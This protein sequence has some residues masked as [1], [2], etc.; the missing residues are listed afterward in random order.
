MSP[1]PFKLA[2]I[3]MEVRGGE[4]ERNLEQALKQIAEA[5]SQGAEVILLPECLDLGWTHPS[6][7]TLAE[8]I[9][10]GR[11]CQRLAEAAQKHE[12]YIC[13]GLTEKQGEKIY[14]SAVLINP[15]GE[16]LLKHRKLN[17]L[18]IGHA[19]YAQG[20]GLQ[21]AQT[22]FGTIGVMICADGFATGQVI[23]RSLCYMGADVILSPCAWAR[24]ADHDNEL[25]PYGSVWRESYKPVAARFSTAIFGTSNVGPITDGPWKGRKCVGCSLAID[26]NGDEMFQGPYGEACILYAEVIP[27]E[28]P[29]RGTGWGTPIPL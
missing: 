21:V 24:P 6:S 20:D 23:S 27:K 4:L 8:P 2:M 25:D 12:V 26:A 28:R 13:S 1:K 18:E 22:E 5:A 3:Q 17:E 9:P 19:Y 15:Q 29:T 16:L 7:Q 10:E 14:N 11:P